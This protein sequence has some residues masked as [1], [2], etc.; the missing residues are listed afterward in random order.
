MRWRTG[1]EGR[2]SYLRRG[3]PLDRTLI[4][5]LGGA[6]VWCG[7]GVLAHNAVKIGAL[8]HDKSTKKAATRPRA[9][10]ARPS[11]ASPGPPPPAYIAA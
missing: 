9:E 10:R 4:D 2:I 11:C 8:V 5:G 3:F 1:S 6:Q 7:L